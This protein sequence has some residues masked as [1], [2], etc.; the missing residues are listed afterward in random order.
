MADDRAERLQ[1]RTQARQQA[2]EMAAA[3][4][5]V[6]NALANLVQVLGT[7]NQRIQDI[8]D[9]MNLGGPAGA[10]GGAA[11]PG[12]GVAFAMS[13][14]TVAPTLLIDYS[15][16]E[17]SYLYKAGKASLDADNLFDCKQEQMSN[18]IEMFEQRALEMGWNDI[19]EG[20]TVITHGVHPNAQQVDGIRDYG[21]LDMT[22]IDR[23]AQTY[24]IEGS[25]RHQ[26]R[27]AQNN[28]AAAACLM[29]SITQRVKKLLLA[30][31]SSWTMNSRADGT[32]INT[33]V[34]MKIYKELMRYS[35]LDTKS[36]DNILRK[37]LRALPD[38]SVSVNGNIHDIHTHFDELYTMLRARGKDIE[39]IEMILFDT[40]RVSPNS[41]F[42][43]YMKDRETEWLEDNPNMLNATYHQIMKKALIKFNT[44]T[45]LDTWGAVSQ[46]QE[47]IIALKAELDQVKGDALKLSKM[48]EKI[49]TNKAK[50]QQATK[51]KDN[52]QVRYV[53]PQAQQ[54][55]IRQKNKKSTF[56][57]TRQRADEAWK[58]IPPKHNE[59]QTKQYDSKTW[60]WCEFHLQW[61][62]HTSSECRLNPNMK[63]IQANQAQVNANKNQ[64][65]DDDGP[66]QFE[67]LM[68]TIAMAAAASQ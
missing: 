63:D 66:N 19:T 53:K 50:P 24:V 35:T 56:N 26:T 64:S 58:K 33:S 14:G 15:T 41:E 1:R 29:D 9:A 57:R 60:H 23:S 20:I 11:G 10:A 2:D 61:T 47:S 6:V 65:H 37:Q 30:D 48:L 25:A 22:E 52:A 3:N 31:K 28:K 36:T 49:K 12:A 32:G 7:Q 34:A 54:Q 8:L 16:K 67:Q 13:P 39:D 68:A 4:Q 38:Y 27:A 43:T 42:R 18:F 40:Y 59:P 21:I 51:P 62:I 55:G 44:M 17:G 46:E 5:D 45:E